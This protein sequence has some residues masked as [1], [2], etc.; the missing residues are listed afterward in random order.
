[1]TVKVKWCSTH[2]TLTKLD[3]QQGGKNVGWNLI[4]S[5]NS[6]KATE[7][8]VFLRHQVITFQQNATKPF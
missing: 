5:T 2:F 3:F 1:M 7:I 6:M 4:L 8:K